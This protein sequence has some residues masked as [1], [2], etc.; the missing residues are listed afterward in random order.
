MPHSRSRHSGVAA[1]AAR[2]AA[3]GIAIALVATWSAAA[4][5][6]RDRWPST[7][8]AP[9]LARVD[10]LRTAGLPRIH[11][12][13]DSLIAAARARGDADLEMVASIRD[14]SIRGFF[15]SRFDTSVALSRRWLDRA[16]ATHDTLSWCLALRTIGYADLARERFASS[17]VTYRE[18]LRLTVR[19]RLAVPEGYARMGVSFIAIQQ[20]RYAEAERGYA[21]AL[22]R[23]GN[24]EPFA[25]RTARA[26]LAHALLKQVRV[27]EA[28]QQYERVAAE[29]RAAHD[30]RNEADALNDLSVIEFQYGD[31][32][33]AAPFFLATARAHRTLGLT[34]RSMQ[35]ARNMGLCLA[36]E[37]RLDEQAAL[38]DSLAR[39]AESLGA[40]DFAADCMADLAVIRRRQGRYP[41]ARAYLQRAPAS[42][43]AVSLAT[44][45]ELVSE[46][47]RIE[48]ADGRPDT[49]ARIARQ[50]LDSLGV[51][52]NPWDR[53]E[54]LHAE[55]LALLGAGDAAAAIAP[56]RESVS[57]MRRPDGQ[58]VSG[59]I[60]C[61]A[62]LGYAF[63]RLGRRDS[64]IVHL[65]RAASAWEHVRAVPN[66]PA[67]RQAYDAL[68]GE[69]FGPLAA[70]LLEPGRGGTAESR[71][72]DAF[73]MVQ[74]FRARTL[75]DV[76]RGAQGRAELPRASVAQLRG[77]LRPG[78]VLFDVF[79]TPESTYLFAVTR[80]AIRVGGTAGNKS[81]LPRL[82]RFRDLVASGD[83]DE[84][85]IAAAATELGSVLLGPVAESLRRASTVLISA[86]SLAALPLGM[87]RLP[88]EVRPIAAG[89]NL[90]FIPSAT[91][92]AA[93]RSAHADGPRRS[94]ITA[95][96]RTTDAKG[97]RLAGV[98]RE[99]KWLARRFPGG[100]V[101]TNDGTRPLAAML[102]TLGPSE[103]LHVAS[104]ARTPAAAPW[105]AGFLLGRG[106]GED[107]YLTAP[108]ISRLRRPARVCVL[109][110]CT[111][112]GAAN[113]GE[114]LPNLASAWLEAG[115]ST[116]I[117]TQWKVD[118]LATARFV[119]DLYGALARG[120]T[121]GESMRAA[122]RAAI[123]SRDR[124]AERFWGGFVL[125][126]DPSTRVE[127]RMAKP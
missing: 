69:L 72:A 108:Q 18:M 32:S 105:S 70:V 88:G 68:P 35:G 87:L 40:A 1:A 99:S 19:A 111:S 92:L 55:G 59:S 56:L 30:L 109:A 23:L 5:S 121:S 58:A 75:E 38:M 21:I 118:D 104:H 57:L 65:Q 11:A 8:H 126:G 91:L 76:L 6:P 37:G 28:R 85:T 39:A 96:S 44:W 13:L 95:L 74:R 119:E 93:A 2:C 90:A 26:G 123:A 71:G 12:Y 33:R 107:A 45:M 63:V 41:E 67:W 60:T 9:L 31:P 29:S 66:D 77:A 125:F 79:A 42:Q 94:T 7:R 115:T 116:V 24:R 110:S 127:L 97:V 62:S 46:R 101:V 25:A 106:A 86:G 117:A 100:R 14:A 120:A 36:A 10:S 102:A 122:Q 114:G 16:R 43:A 22:R 78:E 20:G 49:G 50:A 47:V 113:R 89:R 84:P 124:S 4:A 83:S 112:V 80:E 82:R 53:A 64:A 81:L 27:D 48:I 98:A 52:G 17:L 34:L 103:V 54:V 3:L 51:T 15:E 61:E 73:A